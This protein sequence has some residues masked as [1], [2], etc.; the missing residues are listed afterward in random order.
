MSDRILRW[1][2]VV[3]KVGISRTTLWRMC[4]DGSFPSPIPLVGRLV[5]FPESSIDSWIEKRKKDARIARSE[6][7]G[8]GLVSN[9]P[10]VRGP[11]S[12]EQ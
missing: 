11:V 7:Q 6:I 2:D 4:N 3:K 9:K 1:P 10:P 12:R 8:I 5:G